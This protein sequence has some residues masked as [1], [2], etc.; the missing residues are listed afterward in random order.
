MKTAPVRELK[1]RLSSFLRLVKAGETILVT[2][3]GRVIAELRQP[4]SVG[5]G[6][7]ARVERILSGLERAGRL[8][9]AA[10]AG[11]RCSCA[12]PHG[13]SGGARL[14]IGARGGSRGSGR[15]V[16]CYVDSSVLL[17]MLFGEAGSERL[18][19]LW[20]AADHRISSILLAVESLV[21]LRR[22]HA[23][24]GGRLGPSWLRERERAR[25][26]LLQEVHLLRVDDGTLDVLA[27]HRELSATRA[28]DA[29]HLATAVELRDEGF[30]SDIAV[31]TLDE[32]MRR[33][34]R[35]LKFRVLP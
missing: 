20:A 15:A 32:S 3:H 29:V 8:R 33:M 18:R 27:L 31:A 25:S 24:A 28:L 9:R 1:N 19:E 6:A 11:Q 23:A 34:A 12:H 10:R 35:K 16:I 2:E 14:E 5:R 30:G 13:R 4:E 17:A 26:M 22:T 7:P 21:V